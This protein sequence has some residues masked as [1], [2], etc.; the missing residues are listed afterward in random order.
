MTSTLIRRI[1]PA[2]VTLAAVVLLCILGVKR[3]RAYQAKQP[4]QTLAIEGGTISVPAGFTIQKVAAEDLTQYP[5]L[6]ALDDRGRLF[7]TESSGKNVSGKKM[8]EIPECRI[9]VLEDTDGDGRYDRTKVFADKLSLPMGVLWRGQSLYVASPPDFVRLDDRDNDGVSERREVILTGWNVLNT[10][11]L[12]GPF[13]GPD[14]WMYLTH[15]RHGYKIQTKEGEL[16]EGLASRIWRSRADGTGLERVV[17]GGFDNPVE[18]I[19]TPAGEM[20]GTMTYFTDPQAGQRDAL[21]HYV[22]GG[23]Y[24]KPHPA[25]AEFKRTGDLM[26]V[27]TKFARIAPSGLMQYRGKAFGED[28][29][30]NLFTAQFNPHRVQRHKLFR[31]GATFRTEDSDFITS[32][33][34]DFHPTDILEDA[35][36]SLI[37]LETGG[38]YVDACPLSKIHKGEKRGA[39]YRIRKTD[40][41]KIEDPRGD[42]LKLETLPPADLAKLLPKL[43][44]DARPAVRDRSLELL[45]AGGEKSV[46]ALIQIREQSQQPEVRCAAVFALGRI[47]NPEAAKA[48]RAA[49]ND[50]DFQVR[51][52]AA[53]VAGLNKDAEAVER[54]SRMVKDDEAPA[55]RN[56]ATA[57]GQIGDRRA[58]AALLAAAANAKDRFIE[59]AVIYSLIQLKDQQALIAALKAPAIGTRKAALIALDQSNDSL[60]TAGVV[61]PFLGEGEAELRKAALWVFGHH[62]E[63]PE[64]AAAVHSFLRGRLRAEKFDGNEADSVKDALLAFVA[65]TQVQALIAE[66]LDNETFGSERQL[67]LLEVIERCSLKQLPDAWQTIIAR[68]LKASQNAANKNADAQ[69]RARTIAVIRSRRIATLDD[70]LRRIAADSAEAVDLRLTALSALI[71]RAPK[72]DSPAYQFLLETIAPERDPALRLS[73]AQSLGQSELDREQLLQ[74]AKDHLPKSDS[75][76]LLTL[77]DAFR[78]ARDEETGRALV[79]ALSQPEVNLESIGGKRLEQLFQNFPDSIRASSK[80]LLNRFA[81]EEAAQ[82]KKLRELEPLLTA[83]GDAGAGRNV[84]FG[85]RAACSSCHTIGLEGGRVGPDLT[86]IGAIRSGHDILEAIVFPNATFV[87]GHEPRRVTTK[88][89]NQIYTGVINDFESTRDAIVLMSG[90]NDKI[91]IPREDIASIKPSQVSLMPEGFA[92]QLTQKELTDLLAFLKAQK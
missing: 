4:R 63:K 74:L 41:P 71:T 11:S 40:A 50:A 42:K 32:T 30:G 69:V 66:S 82:L 68:R 86:S 38:W 78:N 80:S 60:I 91:R 72:L 31:E 87:P 19:F 44:E 90:P 65:D 5:M 20:I 62:A 52:A 22:E 70:E 61:A 10:A 17:G 76:T 49:L 35:D 59:H 9:S 43:L 81:E 55:R 29:Q 48:V 73:A 92:A 36:G 64:W 54:L 89:T 16:L 8:A 84:F 24:P 28:F 14:G 13:F 47:A 58:V 2:L 67:F 3:W 12:H 7:V 85:K 25:I 75:L 57:L 77:L 88:S 27:M 21:L 79:A 1:A 23:V 83:G 45:V 56:A 37:L 51:I 26:P 15:G 6:A 34:P 39:I 18:L 53:H 46:A 33:D